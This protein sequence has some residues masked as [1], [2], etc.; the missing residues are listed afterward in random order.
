MAALAAETNVPVEYGTVASHD[1]KHAIVN[2]AT[3]HGL[4]TIVLE[5]RGEEHHAP[6]FGNDREWIKRHTERDVIEV[7]DRGLERGSQVSILTNYGP[8]DVTKLV[9]GAAIAAAQ[10]ADLELLAAVGPEATDRERTTTRE[11]LEAVAAGVAMPATIRIIE[12]RDIPAGLIGATRES[13][14]VVT[15]SDRHGIRGAILGRPADRVVAGTEATAVT[16]TGGGQPPG[17]I[18]RLLH[19]WTGSQ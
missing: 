4:D 19:R 9:V 14:V 11:H 6:V 7:E 18:P 17:R 3:H 2:H 1:I 8:S 13:G 15:S 16:V 12:A 5:R 10:D